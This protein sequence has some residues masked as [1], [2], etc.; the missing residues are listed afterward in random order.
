MLCEHGHKLLHLEARTDAFEESV[1][2]QL[3]EIYEQFD[4]SDE[5]NQVSSSDESPSEE[6][7]TLLADLRGLKY[8]TNILEQHISTLDRSFDKFSDKHVERYKQLRDKVQVLAEG[9]DARSRSAEVRLLGL[10][11]RALTSSKEREEAKEGTPQP[12]DPS[13]PGP[14]AE[15]RF[16]R[17]QPGGDATMPIGLT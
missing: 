9:A 2:H 10:E 3:E 16:G 8:R 5:E 17:P 7:C 13:D 14:G 1:K 11:T 12:T 4:F 15:C 6:W